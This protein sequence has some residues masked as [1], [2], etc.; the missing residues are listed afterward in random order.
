MATSTQG[1]GPYPLSEHWGVGSAA[2]SAG[3][4][5]GLCTFSMLHAVGKDPPLQTELCLVE[6]SQPPRRL[7]STR[8][9]AHLPAHCAM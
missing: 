2:S 1:T 8:M 4:A 7:V 3:M 6:N 9:S 5:V